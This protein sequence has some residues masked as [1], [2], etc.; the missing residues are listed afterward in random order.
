[1]N[2][3]VTTLAPPLAGGRSNTGRL[4]PGDELAAAHG[5]CGALRT[6]EEGVY[7]RKR[8]NRWRQC[9]ADRWLMAKPRNLDA[10][11]QELEAMDLEQLR[12][13]WRR[14]LRTTPPKVSAGL[15]RL[16][17]AHGAQEKVLG[18]LRWSREFGQGAKLIP[19]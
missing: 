19:T 17:L 11:L 14:Q 2:Q 8:E 6:A 16:A 9:L 5:A 13:A 18:G 4:D 3:G 15:L 7:H 10:L 1:R 12:D